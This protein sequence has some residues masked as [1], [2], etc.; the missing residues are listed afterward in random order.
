MVLISEESKVFKSLNIYEL[1]FFGTSKM[2][3]TAYILLIHFILLRH[4]L[5][6]FFIYILA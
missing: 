3:N 2:L 4:C 1:E 5:F 6:N